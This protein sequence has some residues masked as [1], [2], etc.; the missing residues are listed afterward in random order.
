M[1]FR[2]SWHDL[3]ERL[4]ELPEGA[5]F[6]TPLSNDRFQ[7]TGV[8]EHRVIIRFADSGESRPLQ[9]DQFETLYRQVTDSKD[10]FEL[11]RL[12]SDAD[13]YPAVLS[14]HPRFEVN[15]D[16]GVIIETEE[17]TTSLLLGE[18]ASP[19]SAPDE[20]TEPDLDVY[21]DALLLVDAL[22]R[23]EVT[24]LEEV[25]L[26]KSDLF[27]RYHGFRRMNPRNSILAYGS[28]PPRLCRVV[29]SPS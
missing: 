2:V 20:R 27:S 22:E 16:Q 8:Q 3:L 14:L 25:A 10:G 7:V 18:S 12:P 17:P 11:D 13:P 1:S 23:H 6:R 24:A 29:P 5:T 15:D 4:D 28:R 19:D 21:A 9:Q 26:L